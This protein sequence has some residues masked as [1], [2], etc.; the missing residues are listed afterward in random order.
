[1]TKIDIDSL[2]DLTAV[3]EELRLSQSELAALLGVSPRTIQSNEQGWRKPSSALE[4]SILLLLIASRQGEDFTSH[5]CY[6]TLDC[7]P[8]TCDQCLIHRSR[9]GHLC[10]LLT[11]NMCKGRRLYNWQDK[12]QV[13]GE[14]LFLQT[15]LRGKVAHPDPD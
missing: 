4:K 10:W 12:K 6:N 5:T 8:E 2:F 15:L 7:G 1:M 9:Q 11:G 13:C 14:C 3:R